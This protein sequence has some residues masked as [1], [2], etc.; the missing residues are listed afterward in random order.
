MAC[1]SHQVQARCGSVPLSIIT[2]LAHLPRSDL[3]SQLDRTLWCR[4]SPLSPLV[5]LCPPGQAA[6]WHADYTC[7]METLCCQRSWKRV[8]N[9]NIWNNMQMAESNHLVL[10]NDDLGKCS[11][12]MCV[13]QIHKQTVGVLYVSSGSSPGCCSRQCSCTVSLL[14]TT[15]RGIPPLYIGEVLLVL[16]LSHGRLC[17]AYFFGRIH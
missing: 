15:M 12:L 9:T 10:T 8:G 1:R 14:R 7:C 3:C 11:L 5:S 6:T 16:V 2:C 4:Y 13:D 17:P